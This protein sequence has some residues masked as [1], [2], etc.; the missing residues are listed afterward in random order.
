MSSKKTTM[1]E[2]EAHHATHRN[3]AQA[4]SPGGG[5]DGDPVRDEVV[6]DDP[7]APDPLTELAGE[8]DRL[9]AEKAELQDRYVRLQAEFQNSRKRAERDRAE[10]A[11]Y[12]STEAVRALLPI[13]DDF[14]R[15]LKLEGA[16]KEYA[17]GMELIYQRLFESLKRLGLEPIVSAGQAFDPHVHHA[18]EMV[19]SEEAAGNTVIDEYQRGYNFKGR[20][21]RP[22]MVKVAVEPASRKA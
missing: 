13:L 6:L 16:G 14:E 1:H 5:P 2:R 21:L 10:F 19:E 15:A 18:V 12:A 7:P 22:A 9:A 11:E 8:R 4:A 3:A 20:L 17:K